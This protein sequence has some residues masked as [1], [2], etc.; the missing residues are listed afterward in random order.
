MAPARH[1]Q[2][3]SDWALRA[4]WYDYNLSPSSPVYPV[5]SLHRR[6]TPL[7]IDLHEGFEAGIILRGKQ[8]RHYPQSMLSLTAGDAW[9][10][11]MWEPHGW[12]A[13]VPGT[14]TVVLVFLP[15]FLGE[16]MIGEL[17]WLSL[18]ASPPSDRLWVRDGATRAT[19]L[20]IGRELAEEISRERRS[21][22]TAVRLGLLRL[23]LV[24]SREW[25]PPAT[26][27]GA[28]RVGT[29]TLSRVMPAISLIQQRKPGTVGMNE[30]AEACGLSRSRFAGLFRQTMG[31]SFGQFALRTRLAFAAHRLLTTDMSAETIGREVGFVD[32]SHFHRTF[33]KRYGC[34]PRM[35]RARQADQRLAA[36][37]S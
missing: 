29:S 36:G 32:G 6:A 37:P 13:A 11:P 21:W 9:L 4:T 20:S 27:S 24:L 5:V 8:E 12:R 10:Q 25:E 7:R 18:F 31:T 15:D 35:Y 17:P 19:V 33:V 16:E 26:A 2:V 30:A 3:A 34:S 28:T 14:E 23:L 1:T 22:L